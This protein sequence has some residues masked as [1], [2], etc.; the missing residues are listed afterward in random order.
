MPRTR[1]ALAL[2]VLLA[3][4]PA[5]AYTIYLKDGAR[6][7]AREQY[8]VIDQTAYIVLPNG[9]TTFIDAAEIDVPRTEEANQRQ[10]GSALV[11]EGGQVRELTAEDAQ[12]VERRRTLADLISDRGSAPEPLP[13]ARREVTTQAAED[14]IRT[15]G[16][17]PDLDALPPRPLSDL[18]LAAEIKAMFVAQGLELVEVHQGTAPRRPL[19]RVTAGSEASV[20]RAVAVSCAALM[21]LRE[22]RPDQVEALELVMTTPDR[23]R[24][25]QFLWVT[26]L[27]KDEMVLLKRKDGGKGPATIKEALTMKV[28]SQRGDFA[29]EALEDLGFTDIDLAS[30]IDL[31]VRKLLSGR[32]DLVPTSIKTYESLVQQG[33]PVEKAM[34]MSGQIYGLA[35]NAKTPAEAV[36]SLQA[37]LDKLILSGGQDR[38]FAAYGLPPNQRTAENGTQK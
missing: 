28:G 15:P 18:G 8:K 21:R 25:G 4:T 14:L 36:A 10:L 5:A 9:T 20:F 37:E 19:L 33:Q 3:A 2:L 32:V 7:I 30:D 12:R 17:W 24:A 35:C 22:A 1:A 11:L 6:I 29:V 13:E 34:L 26:P 23:E 31:S 27:L 16:G 38:I